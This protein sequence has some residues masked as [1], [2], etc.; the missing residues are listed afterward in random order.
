MRL[1]LSEKT[2]KK[3]TDFEKKIDD[4]IKRLGTPV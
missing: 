1:D 3:I 4:A 2:K